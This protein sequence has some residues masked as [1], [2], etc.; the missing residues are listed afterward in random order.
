MMEKKYGIPWFKVNFV[1][2]KST[3]KSLRKMAAYFGDKELIDNV[4][5]VVTE[6]LEAVE[7]TRL[8][9]KAKC[10]GKIAMLFVGGSRAH[11]YQ[12]LFAEIGMQTVSA[13]YEFAHRDDYEGRK[14]LGSIVV[15]ADTRN[16]EEL[17][18]VPDETRYSP[19]KSEEEIA[20]LKSE[21]FEF[22]DYK[23]LMPEMPDRTLIIDDLNHYE[24]EVLIEK[25]KPAIFCAGIKEK[26]VVQKLGIPLKQLHSYDYSGPYAGF[27]GAVNFYIEIDRLVNSNMFRFVKAPWQNSPELAGSYGWTN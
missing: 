7:K 9:V 21:G 24:A 17:T 3:A 20:K 19:R 6:E 13:G 5:K 25:Y 1:G 26:Y 16:I 12:D 22:S 15:D 23:G 4:E 8:E 2:A 10:E 11:H 18:V 27:E 14:V